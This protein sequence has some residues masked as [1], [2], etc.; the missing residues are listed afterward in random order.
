MPLTES[1]KAGYERSARSFDAYRSPSTRR[2]H[3]AWVS[4]AQAMQREGVP[5]YFESICNR[6]ARLL[7]EGIAADKTMD[8]LCASPTGDGKGTP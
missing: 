2:E 6:A 8:E 7:R 3:K 5:L 1:Q 4:A